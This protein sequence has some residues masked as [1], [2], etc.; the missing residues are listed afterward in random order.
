MGHESGV[1]AK[2]IAEARLNLWN[3]WNHVHLRCVS[4]DVR[5]CLG[6]LMGAACILKGAAGRDSIVGIVL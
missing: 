2:H 3:Q 6:P 4:G 5:R 1:Q